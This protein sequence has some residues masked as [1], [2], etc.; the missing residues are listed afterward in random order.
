MEIKQFCKVCG[1]EKVLTPAGVRKDGTTWD[2]FY[3]CPNFKDQI[4]KQ[5]KANKTLPNAPGSPRTNEDSKDGF[6]IMS[7]EFIALKQK[8]EQ[9]IKAIEENITG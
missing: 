7:E 5:A 9:L 6:A 1:A 4:H 8:I 2:A 3:G